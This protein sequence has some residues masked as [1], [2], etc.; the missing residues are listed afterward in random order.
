MPVFSA[1]GNLKQK[2]TFKSDSE[3]ERG[4][5][6]LRNHSSWTSLN[7]SWPILQQ[8]FVHLFY[9]ALQHHCINMFLSGDFAP[10]IRSSNIWRQILLPQ[11]AEKGLSLTR[12]AVF[13]D[14]IKY[15]I[16]YS[17]DPCNNL[18]FPKWWCK[19]EK[20]CTVCIYYHIS[21]IFNYS[22]GYLS[23][24]AYFCPRVFG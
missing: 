18:P 10:Q 5:H 14:A 8:L 19:A 7:S 4:S 13:R 24:V 1:F 2:G 21:I 15:A 9:L 3:E 16:M 22:R 23:G 20:S 17:I 12:W 6:S 11:L